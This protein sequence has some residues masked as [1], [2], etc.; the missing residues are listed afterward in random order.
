MRNVPSK[1]IKYIVQGGT[2]RLDEWMR[3]RKFRVT[4]DKY[5][6]RKD[7][8]ERSDRDILEAGRFSEGT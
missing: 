8:C 6:L 7:L 4:L 5:W 3:K 1:T 2:R